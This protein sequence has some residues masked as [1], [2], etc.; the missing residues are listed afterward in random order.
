M[1]IIQMTKEIRKAKLAKLIQDL[2]IENQDQLLSWLLKA[3]VRATQAS[4]S[5][6]LKDLGAVKIDRFYRLPEI[7]LGQS[8]IV[9]R[10]QAECAGGHM[11]VF[12]TD[13]LHAPMLA[14]LIDRSRILGVIGTIAGDDTV[15]VALSETKFQRKAIQK[16]ISLVKGNS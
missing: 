13:P 7:S 10:L 3:G 15:F 5:R 9:N 14:A 1:N 16:I 8:K 2:N 6:D 4:I 12:K 11:I